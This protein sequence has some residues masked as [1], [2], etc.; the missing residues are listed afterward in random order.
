MPDSELNFDD[1][2]ELTDDE[3]KRMRPVGRPKSEQTKYMISFRIDPKL[4]KSLRQ[5]A[6]EQNKP[7]QT[8]IHE[9][10]TK[11]TKKKAA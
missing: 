2:P 9:L 6:E 10:L 4:L 11:A 7:Y 8:L 1:I 3:L 5:M